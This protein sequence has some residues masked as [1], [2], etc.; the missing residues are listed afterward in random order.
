M[1]PDPKPSCDCGTQ[2]Q[3]GTVEYPFHEATSIGTDVFVGALP[4][5]DICLDFAHP[6]PDDGEIET[7]SLWHSQG[8]IHTIVKISPEAA[9]ALHRLLGK[10]VGGETP[11]IHNL[12]IIE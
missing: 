8:K 9:N 5:G 10:V 2:P 7:S 11:H 3:D 12:G 4:N 6:I 1:T